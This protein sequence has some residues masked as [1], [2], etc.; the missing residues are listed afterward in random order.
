M[1]ELQRARLGLPP[2]SGGGAMNGGRTTSP[3]APTSLQGKGKGIAMASTMAS[4][5]ASNYANNPMQAALAMKRSE[6][7]QMKIFLQLLQQRDDSNAQ[8]VSGPTVPTA[9][10]RRM[11]HRQGVGFLDNTVAATVS[12]AADRFLAT[13]LQQAVACRDQRLK[14]VELAR[15]A[16]RR[17]KRHFEHYQADTD[18]RR[19]R[20]ILHAKEREKANLAAIAAAEALGSKA[21]AS[22]S[23]AAG[24]GGAST[25][26]NETKSKR[27]KKTEEAVP[28]GNA[29]VG[30]PK[31]EDDDD[32]SFDSM[33]EEEEYYQEFYGN[34]TTTGP[35]V[36]DGDNVD[37]EKLVLKDLVRPLEAWRVHVRG[38]MSLGPSPLDVVLDATDSADEDDEY[39]EEF[40]DQDNNNNNN[41]AAFDEAKDENN[42]AKDSGAE[43]KKENGAQDA[44]VKTPAA[45]RVSTPV[46]PPST[47]KS[48]K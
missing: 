22:A 24:V 21:A 40:N 18:D 39:D 13:V 46:P 19:R 12:A 8:A 3:A 35:L 20:K 15:E 37:D 32:D 1:I 16:A 26:T 42:T 43:E 2:T 31:E 6:E 30:V 14:G 27:K 38:K 28:N 41:D 36:D 47:S 7:A 23:N 25:P 29:P 5:A 45:S 9:L 34:D 17:R 48:S 11:L 4:E 44:V 10:S 33:D